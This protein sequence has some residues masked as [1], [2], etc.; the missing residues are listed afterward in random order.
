MELNGEFPDLGIELLGV[1]G[2]GLETG[3]PQMVAGRFI[4]LLQD[5][6]EVDAWTQWEV[7]YRDVIILDRDGVPVG[8]FNLTEHDLSMMGEYESLKGML[9]DFAM[10]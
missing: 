5:V 7:V 3:V 2:V 4:P 6:A 1:N 8:V 9:I 10:M